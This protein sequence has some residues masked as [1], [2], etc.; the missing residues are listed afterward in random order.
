VLVEPYFVIF[1]VNL[2]DNFHIYYRRF[3]TE[4]RGTF[5]A[6]IISFIEEDMLLTFSQKPTTNS[7]SKD[8]DLNHNFAPLLS[9]VPFDIFLSFKKGTL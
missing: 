3:L 1:K 9:N 8:E 5:F 4:F 6:E 2:V 7:Y